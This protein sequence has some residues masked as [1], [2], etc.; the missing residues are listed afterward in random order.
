M[1]YILKPHAKRRMRER[2]I[3][4]ELISRALHNPTQIGYDAKNRL[5]I[6]NIYV[7]NNQKRLLLIVGEIHAEILE[8]ITVIDT[9]KIK[10]YL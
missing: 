3:P 1:K 10:K 7:K 8:I 2:N 4:E 9:S 6:K 5:L